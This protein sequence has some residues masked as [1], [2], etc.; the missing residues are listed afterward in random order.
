M[1]MFVEEF[2]IFEIGVNILIAITECL[3]EETLRTQWRALR[4]K[5][6]EERQMEV[7]DDFERWN[8]YLFYVVEDKREINRSLKYEIEHDTVSSRKIIVDR[9]EFVDGNYE[10]LIASYIKYDIE[11]LVDE[12]HKM[13]F[14]INKSAQKLAKNED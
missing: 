9:A 13:D 6:A 8:F 4:N 14:V 2:D 11:G 5:L 7:M 3:S 12:E 1:N 10:A